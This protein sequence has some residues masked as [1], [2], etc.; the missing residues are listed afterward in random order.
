LFLVDTNVISAGAPAR[1]ANPQLAAWMDAHSAEIFLSA[2]TIAEIDSGIAQ[3][4]RQGALKKA[5]SLTAWLETILHLY[6]ARIMPF[7]TA[8]ARIAGAL[9]D[10]ARAAGLAPGFADLIIAATA[11]R[12]GLTLLTRNLRHFAFSGIAV[13]DPFFSTP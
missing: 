6:S 7:E 13:H 2:V 9:S 3:S 1:A 10:A 5:A 12:H 8:T 4:R 11:K